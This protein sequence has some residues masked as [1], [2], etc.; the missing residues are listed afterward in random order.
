MMILHLDTSDIT[1][2]NHQTYPLVLQI[3]NIFFEDVI[4]K[5][6]RVVKPYQCQ[7]IASYQMAFLKKYAIF[8]VHKSSEGKT[9]AIVII[10]LTCPD[11]IL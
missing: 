5:E 3:I 7:M 1:S 8:F 11:F 2:L 6:S 10:T 4:K 9:C